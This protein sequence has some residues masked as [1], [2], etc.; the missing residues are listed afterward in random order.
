MSWEL[1][2]SAVVFIASASIT[3]GPNNIMIM[4]SGLNHGVKASL[5]HL[6]GISIGFPCLFIAMGLGAGQLFETWPFLHTLIT[7]LGLVYLLYLA[8]L[9]ATSDP[10][11]LKGKQRQ[12]LTF[13]QA[14]GF[15]L[16]N[17]KAW[18]MGMSAIAVF[19]QAEQ[20]MLPQVLKLTA[21]FAV[22]T[23]LSCSIWLVFGQALQKVLKQAHHQVIFNRVMASLLV[24]SII[25]SI[26]HLF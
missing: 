13:I 2:L 11:E 21:I 25:P 12:P 24:L 9:I 23:L 10:T 7:A 6:L 8:Y 22:F 4:T 1:F 18:I 3:P 20:A 14:A 17:G 16:L 26:T 5:N 15:Q 19:T